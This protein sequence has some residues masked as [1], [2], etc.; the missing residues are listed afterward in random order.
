MTKV[1]LF[2][3]I[4]I[5]KQSFNLAFEENGKMRT[6]K[7][8]YTDEGMEEC[9]SILPMGI[10]CVM[11]STGTYHCRLAY[12]LFE[13]G[14]PLSVVNPLSVK[15]FSQA[16]MLRTKTDKADCQMLLKYGRHFTPV[17]WKPKDNCYVELQQLINMSS[18]LIKQESAMKNQMEAI[19]YSV[20]QNQ[21]VKV[22]LE[23]RI[24]QIQQDLKEID[25][26][27]EKLIVLHEK[28][29]FE[30]LTGIPGIGKKTAIV[31][32]A[33]TQGMKE[34]DSAKQI[35][36]YF[37]L[38]PRIYESGTS[39]KGKTKICKMGMEM[40]RKLLYMCALSAKKCNKTC[41]ELYNRLLQKGKKKK[42]ALIAVANKLLKQAFSIIKNN[43]IYNVNFLSKKFAY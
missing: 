22:K 9:L 21:W 23:E 8:S 36:S 31:L 15:R 33:L 29:N 38:C 30:H 32:I 10:Q 35:S 5:S 41:Q 17:L 28:E 13:H 24:K 11:E 12:F 14:V 6:R 42:L 39:V 43:S 7:F 1:Q 19:D 37:G 4:D 25:K 2:C 34:F 40:I 16:L 27:M 20:V 3:G 26:A 18:Q